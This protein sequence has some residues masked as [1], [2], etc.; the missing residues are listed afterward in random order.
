MAGRARLH[1]FRVMCRSM[2]NWEA[3]YF[4]LGLLVQVYVVMEL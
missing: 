2:A 3:T 1:G 4:C